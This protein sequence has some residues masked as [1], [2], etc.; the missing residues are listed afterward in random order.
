MDLLNSIVVFARNHGVR[1]EVTRRVNAKDLV[2]GGVG[3]PLQDMGVNGGV[4]LASI[5]VRNKQVIGVLDGDRVWPAGS[6]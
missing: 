4:E 1:M 5:L 3:V 2:I 6:V